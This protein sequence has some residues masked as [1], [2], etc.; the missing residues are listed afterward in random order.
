M[1]TNHRKESVMKIQGMT[2]IELLSTLAISA[3]LSLVAIPSLYDTLQNY[4][5]R[6][7]AQ[8]LFQALNSA[9][10]SSVMRNNYVTVWN[11]DGNWAND[12]E[13]FLDKN[14]DGERSSD[15][16]VLYRAV[17]QNNTQ[18]SGNRW[19]SNYIKFHPDGSAQTASG[20]FQ[21]GTITVCIP[22]HT[23]AYQI[24]ISIGGR[25]RMIKTDIDEC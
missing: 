7:S 17:N 8:V 24:I 4:R 9:R 5:L 12:V 13:I 20:A 10:A 15:E 14:E 16:Q 6:S 19:V 21:V 22:N 18:I 11:T 1:I 25:I 2:L 3:I 23:T